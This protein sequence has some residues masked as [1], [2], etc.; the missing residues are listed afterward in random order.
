MVTGGG[1]GIGENTAQAMA[2]HGV[3]VPVDGGAY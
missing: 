1:A 2:E 3:I